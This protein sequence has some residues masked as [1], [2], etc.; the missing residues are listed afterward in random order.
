VRTIRI[1]HAIYRPHHVRMCGGIGTRLKHLLPRIRAK[2][3]HHLTSVA[4]DDWTLACGDHDFHAARGA[5][6]LAEHA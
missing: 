3:E 1:C 4:R 6:L 2:V 5:A